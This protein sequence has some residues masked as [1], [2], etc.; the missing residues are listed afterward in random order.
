MNLI[1]V[2]LQRRVRRRPGEPDDVVP[3]VVDLQVHLADRVVMT[4]GIVRHEDVT[5]DLN[6]IKISLS[7]FELTSSYI[8]NE[9]STDLGVIL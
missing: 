7:G 5:V 1:V 4:T 3:A 9:C 8:Q 6:K 2:D